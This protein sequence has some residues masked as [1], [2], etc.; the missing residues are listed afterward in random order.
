MNYLFPLLF[1]SLCLLIFLFCYI[2]ERPAA[3]LAFLGR[4]AAGLLFIRVFNLFCL[5]REITTHVS[6]NLLTVLISCILGI[7]GVLLTYGI[8]LLG[9]N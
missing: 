7:P 3:L 1:F 9:L 4:G 5:S 8:Q 2:K 6:I